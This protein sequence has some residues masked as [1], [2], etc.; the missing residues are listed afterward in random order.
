MKKALL[1]VSLFTAGLSYAQDCSKLFIS[2]YVEG[3]GNNKALEIYNPT[4][5]PIDLAN[6]FIAR[7]N[8]GTTTATVANCA[9]L[10]GTVPA[11][12]TY[13]AVLGV[14]ASNATA[15]DPA[16][17]VELQALADGFYSAVYDE[18]NGLRFNGDDAVLLMK[19]SIA[20][21]PL[22]TEV[23][24]IP[25]VE[26]I[27]VLGKVGQ[28]PDGGW[29]TAAPYDGSA[30]AGVKVT[31]DHTLLRKSS[32]KKGVVDPFPA[33]FN[34]LVEWDTLPPTIVKLDANGDTVFSNNGSVVYEG[35]WST[36][37]SHDCACNP[38]SVSKQTLVQ[39]EVFPNPSVNGVFTVASPQVIKTVNVYNGLGQMIKSV[40]VNTT[41][42]EINV[43]SA[44]GVYIV[45]I[46]TAE[47][48]ATKRMIVKN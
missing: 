34:A 40:K 21:L 27:D 31:I 28:R 18:S 30:G 2:E 39:M 46:E 10:T 17:W 41:I 20:G 15:N 45:K 4:S 8:N 22:T 23:G 42:T 13:V 38:L 7:Y 43:G 1:F 29:S 11:H 36:L 26:V 33:F 6:Y 14:N 12:G 44:S 24:S 3:R 32:I 16:V 37:G 9:D 25:G 47:G 5:A 48:I 19:G 35:N